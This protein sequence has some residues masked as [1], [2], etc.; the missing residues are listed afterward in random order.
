M[1]GLAADNIP[2][3]APSTLIDPPGGIDEGIPPGV[4]GLKVKYDTVGTNVP[5]W[6]SSSVLALSLE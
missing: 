3:S 5:S 6:Y 2:M 4:P 1:V